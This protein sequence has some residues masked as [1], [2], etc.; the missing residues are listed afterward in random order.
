M[1]IQTFLTGYPTNLTVHYQR[2]CW[3]D[4][5]LFYL[6][7]QGYRNL[8]CDGGSGSTKYN[9]ASLETCEPSARGIGCSES[10]SYEGRCQALSVRYFAQIWS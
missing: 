5:T 4:C 6:Q 9:H 1:V 2:L 3:N 8:P 10:V 7:G